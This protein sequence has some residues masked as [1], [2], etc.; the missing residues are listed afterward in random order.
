LS[1]QINRELCG[2]CGACVDV[3]PVEAIQLV[4]QRAMIVDAL[5][6]QCD[7]CADVC[8]NGAINTDSVP[9]G[10]ISISPSSAVESRPIPYYSPVALSDT[11]TPT[12]SLVSLTRTAL[13]GFEHEIAPRL[14]DILINAL[15]RRLTRPPTTAIAPCV[16]PAQGFTARGKGERRRARYRRGNAC[17]TIHNERR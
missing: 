10:S 7:D 14:A 5:C 9:V 15:E 17:N 16:T 4:D 12:R 2:G 8:P 11:V 3:C 13:V 1:V 6:T